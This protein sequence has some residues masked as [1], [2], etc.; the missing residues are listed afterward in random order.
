MVTTP[1][2]NTKKTNLSF[3]ETVS[4]KPEEIVERHCMPSVN[5]QLNS[6]SV[7]L[8]PAHNLDDNRRVLEITISCIVER[9]M[10]F[11]LG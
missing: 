9:F 6:I 3:Q 11:F 2:H 5:Y 4:F 7:K 8:K 1:V 10:F